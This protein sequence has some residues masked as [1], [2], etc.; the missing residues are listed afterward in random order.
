[1][2][3]DII[4]VVQCLERKNGLYFLLHW[5]PILLFMKQSETFYNQSKPNFNFCVF[6][7]ILIKINFYCMSFFKK[8]QADFI[9]LLL[10]KTIVEKTNFSLN[11]KLQRLNPDPPRSTCAQ[12]ELFYLPIADSEYQIF[13][14][15]ASPL[16]RPRFFEIFLEFFCS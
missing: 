7:E 10:S 3:R 8:H 5:P 4:R 13:S 1:M 16:P 12:I 6:I 15:I 9:W 2:S 11:E 14:P